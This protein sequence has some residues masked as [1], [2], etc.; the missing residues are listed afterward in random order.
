VRSLSDFSINGFEDVQRAVPMVRLNQLDSLLFAS[1]ARVRRC[2]GQ[3][4]YFC[5][6][7]APK[8]VPSRYF[9]SRPVFLF[10]ASAQRANQQ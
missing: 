8:A 4:L 5:F 1:S 9:G 2:F 7:S 3:G 10:S 6:P